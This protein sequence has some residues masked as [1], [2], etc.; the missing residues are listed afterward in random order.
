MS[1]STRLLIANDP[2]SYREVIAE[3]IRSLRPRVEIL[4]AEPSEL[5]EQVLSFLPHVVV[6]SRASPAVRERVPSWVELYPGHATHSFV[7]VDGRVTKAEDIQLV[8]LLLV[9]DRAD[10]LPQND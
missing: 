7:S 2:R 9:V 6:C 10:H 3:A 8:D 1:G 5:E 4:T